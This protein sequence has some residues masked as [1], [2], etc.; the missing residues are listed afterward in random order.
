M[1]DTN[2]NV[3]EELTDRELRISHKATDLI[4]DFLDNYDWWS[5]ADDIFYEAAVDVLIKKGFVKVDTNKLVAAAALFCASHGIPLPD[6]KKNVLAYFRC[7]EKD[8]VGLVK[9]LSDDVGTFKRMYEA[10]WSNIKSCPFGFSRAPNIKRFY[11]AETLRK[12]AYK[13]LNDFIYHYQWYKYDL[14]CL[15]MKAV[16]LLVNKEGFWKATPNKLAAAVILFMAKLGIPLPESEA[17]VLKY[18]RVKKGEIE[19]VLNALV[20][21][22]E[23]FKKIYGKYIKRK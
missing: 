1:F 5:F 2:I 22:E 10:R 3:E 7:N 6:S 19:P 17:E 14:L 8:I 23:E 16:G 21:N 12:E 15:R 13:I 20:A 11:A 9:A 18:F 4:I